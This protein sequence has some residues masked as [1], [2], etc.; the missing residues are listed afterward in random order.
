MSKAS[1]YELRTYALKRRLKKKL[2]DK[3]KQQEKA[4]I[5]K[6]KKRQQEK[7]QTR[8]ESRS[9]AGADINIGFHCTATPLRH[10]D[11]MYAVHSVLNTSKHLTIQE[12]MT[13]QF[14]FQLGPILIAMK[15]YIIDDEA[16]KYYRDVVPLDDVHPFQ[17]FRYMIIRSVENQI[18][19]TMIKRN[20]TSTHFLKQTQAD[21]EAIKN[22]RSIEI[23]QM[24]IDIFT[25]R[26]VIT[27]I[28]LSNNNHRIRR[29]KYCWRKK[30][31][32]IG[33]H[34]HCCSGCQ[35]VFYCS[36]R[37]QKKSWFLRHQYVCC[38]L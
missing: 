4:Q 19:E 17:L 34:L 18:I 22:F 29:C 14:Q 21:L 30:N 23:E 9:S 35:Q 2:D 27:N 15:N 25:I 20:C 28:K 16:I 36:V 3:R 12:I 37:C 1:S 33:S 11:I 32:S 7:A 24:I 31:K 38:H 10:N 13:T 8:R 5:I 6:A 26:C